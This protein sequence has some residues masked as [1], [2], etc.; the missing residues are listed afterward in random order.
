MSDA[1]QYH[2]IIGKTLYYVCMKNGIQY[3][4]LVMSYLLYVEQCCLR[5]HRDTPAL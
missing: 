5:E 2:I 1:G 3:T 4:V